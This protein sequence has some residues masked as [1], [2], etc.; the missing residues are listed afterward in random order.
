MMQAYYISGFHNAREIREVLAIFSRD[1]MKDKLGVVGVS[2]RDPADDDDEYTHELLKI[3]PWKKKR[4]C[5]PPN[6]R[7]GLFF[8]QGLRCKFEEKK[9]HFGPIALWEGDRGIF[10][11]YFKKD[12]YF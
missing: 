12:I 2:G 11:K 4:T 7:L 3:G 9:L 8:L 10:L 5:R 1:L 6:G